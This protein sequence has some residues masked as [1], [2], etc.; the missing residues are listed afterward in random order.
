[1]LKPR[2]VKG[3]LTDFRACTKWTHFENGVYFGLP[4]ACSSVKRMKR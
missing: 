2:V 4:I 1:M 3:V